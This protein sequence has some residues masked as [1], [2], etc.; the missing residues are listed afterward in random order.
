[1]TAESILE[2]LRPLGSEGYKRTMLRH[3]I[4][5]PF[6]GVKVEELKKIQKRI[7]MDYRLALDLYATGNSDAMYL[8]GL[9]ADDAQM[10][11]ADLDVWVDAAYCPLHSECTV[12]WVAAGSPHAI[13]VA[14]KWIGSGTEMTACAGWSTLGS[15]VGITPDA[16]IDM[17]LFEGLLKRVRTTIHQ[18]PNRVR[19]AMNAFVIA[20]GTYV[21]P[22]TD[23]AVETAVAVG[24]V[25]VDQGN[26]ACQVPFAPDYIEKAKQRGVIGKKRKSAKC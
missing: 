26:T 11:V 14:L 25:S 7:K 5:E 17:D 13:E 12:A 15:W 22:L 2:E 10:T 24:R 3:G 21:T 19:S 1:M 16:A 18:Q 9:I 23:A 6:F 8:A 4:R 20:V